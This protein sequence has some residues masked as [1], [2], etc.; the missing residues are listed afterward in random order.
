M[1]PQKNIKKTHLRLVKSAPDSV[2]LNTELEH[3]RHLSGRNKYQTILA[4]ANSAAL[5]QAMPPQDLFLLVKELGSADVPELL[6]MASSEQITLC[7]DMD[8]WHADNMDAVDAQFWLQQLQNINETD[9][10]RILDTMDF[11][12]LALL[13]K[14][15]IYITT[16]LEALDD[17]EREEPRLRRDQLYEYEYRDPEQAKWIEAL[18]D[19]L[20]SERQGLYLQLMETVRHETELV[21]EEDVY[22]DRNGRLA[23]L[24]FIETHEARKI[25]AW[26]NPEEF[27]PAEFTKNQAD[28]APENSEVPVPGFALS[29]THPRDLLAD[30]MGNSMNDALCQ[31]LTY[32]LNRAMSADQVDIGDSAQVQESLEDVYNYL[33]IALGFLAGSDVN[34]ATELFEQVYL[35]SLY[36]LGFCLTIALQ[37][38]ARVVQ[39]SPAGSYLDG[40][41]AALITALKHSK[42]RFYSGVETTTR[43]NERPF[44]NYSDVKAVSAELGTVEA[45][46]P[47][48]GTKGVFNI[49]APDELDLDGCIP[50]QAS[51]VTLSEL[52]LTAIANKILG[53]DPTPEPIAAAEL[54]TLHHALHT[55]DNFAELRQ[56]THAWLESLAP[57]SGAFAEFCFEIWEHEFYALKPENL[58]PQYV[59]GLLIR[60]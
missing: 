55:E 40:P 37:R 20:F 23:D 57:G 10:M 54:V 13:F 59:G 11:D 1:A 39:K 28:F 33:N 36:R 25:R 4:S 22:R 51:E 58:Q 26:L 42:P 46:L 30:V 6:S 18:L 15:Q 48:F 45:L 47:L 50:P 2:T 31:E 9:T 38:R 7:V 27:D 24:G 35:Q 3:L 12:L 49:P 8:C 41:D 16:G 32:L 21:F 43:A 56:Q 19:L 5:V 34:R 44:R 29:V 53:H 14:K 60:L 17:D 52:F